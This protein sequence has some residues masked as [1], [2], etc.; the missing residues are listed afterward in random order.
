[1]VLCFFVGVISALKSYF[2]FFLMFFNL[3]QNICELL[4][5]SMFEMNFC[6]PLYSQITQL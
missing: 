3:C 5:L 1:M 4:L 6:L 2:H